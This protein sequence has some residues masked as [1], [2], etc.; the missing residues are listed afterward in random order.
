MTFAYSNVTLKVGMRGDDVYT[1]QEDLNELGFMTVKPTGYYGTITRT[2]VIKM[3]K[4]YGL[5]VDGIAGKQT[6]GKLDSL[7]Q[8]DAAKAASS[9]A[10]AAAENADE[11]QKASSRGELHSA[12]SIIDYAK[13]FKGVKYVW[14]GTTAK[15]FDCSGFVK[16]V[17]NKFD[18]SLSRT[19]AAQAKN[20]TYIKKADLLPGDLV[21]FDTNG[22]KNR[23]NHVGIYIGG[24]KMIHSSSLH[25]G[26]VISTIN[27]GFY[28]KCY[29]TARRVLK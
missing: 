8:R 19:S 24:G 7:M 25:K 16:Y 17:Y 3:Q 9:T 22:G 14:G 12:E 1:L 6:L 4:Q 21:F 15:G 18:V 2:A 23:I 13:R 28:A 29:M 20:G 10:A 26:V 5:L 27:S 11:S